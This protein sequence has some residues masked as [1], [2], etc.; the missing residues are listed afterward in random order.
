MHDSLELGVCPVCKTTDFKFLADADAVRSQMED[1]WQFH[2]R[3]LKPGAPVH[4]LFDRAVFSQ[5]PP[6]HIVECSSCG[7]VL[8]NPRESAQTIVDL[9]AGE[10]PPASALEDL[11]AA[12]VGFY[13]PRLRRL[14][15]LLGRTGNVLE[16]GSYLGAFLHCAQRRGWQAEGVDVNLSANEFARARGGTV[17]DGTIEDMNPG[18]RYD[19]VTFWN[20]LDQLPDP[21]RALRHAHAL[22]N[23]GGMVVARVPNGACYAQLHDAPVGR[24]LLAHNNLLGFPYRYG[25]TPGSLRTL[26]HA[27][28]F[29][30]VKTIGDTLVST[31][32]SWTKGWAVLEE[33]ALKAI[34][35][36]LAPAS[37]APWIEVYA[38]VPY[39][40]AE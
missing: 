19:V 33:R 3:R 8:R 20:C 27:T 26:L 18:R 9:Y 37:R 35:R 23:E 6:M 4:Q 29:D 14:E 21:E 36:L 24:R 40:S 12:Q 22:L 2:T 30:A 34:T 17:Q 10:E 7:T 31:A 13:Q 16:V 38:R 1:L 25:F 32:G 39:A 28:G 15:R 11:F 5:T